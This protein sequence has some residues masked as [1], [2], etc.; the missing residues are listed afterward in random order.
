MYNTLLYNRLNKQI[1]IYFFRT[2][3][4]PLENELEIH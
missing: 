2:N 3:F 1:L 4:I